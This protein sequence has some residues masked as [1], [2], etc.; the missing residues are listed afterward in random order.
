MPEIL[1][2]A[3]KGNVSYLILNDLP[4][5]SLTMQMMK[6]I[7]EELKSIDNDKNIRVVVV[8]S[9]SNKIFCSGHNLKEVK[10]MIKEDDL[11]AQKTLFAE[12]SNM[13]KSL[14]SLSKPVIAKVN[15]IA[16]AAGTQLVASCDLAY[17]SLEST[18]ATPGVNIGLFC[19]TPS[20]AVSR[21]IG[22]KPMME[23]LFTG[24]PIDAEK[25]KNIGLI[26]D[27][28]SCVPAAVA[29]PLTLAITGFDKLCRLFIIF[30][31]SAKRV[32]CALRSSSL[33]IDF[34]SF[35]LCPEQ[36]IL[37]LADSTTTT[38]IF[39]SLSIDFNSS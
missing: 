1:N 29:I 30:E 7:Q 4:A 17:G 12:C 37:L 27:A 8:E 14:Q 21:M 19:H 2:R 18:S 23:M 24:A 6:Y 10:S 32:F 16:T 38:L 39:L 28:T 13:M 26:N 33:I 22:K 36:K 31:H 34:T 3:D 11:N 9:A 20:V 25:A 5:N 15:G 35:K